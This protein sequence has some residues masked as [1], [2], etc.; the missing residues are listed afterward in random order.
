MN[1]NYFNYPD[2]ICFLAHRDDKYDE[3]TMFL[4]CTYL[5][6]NTTDNKILTNRVS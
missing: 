4:I 2:I 6:K 5:M 1:H 3:E